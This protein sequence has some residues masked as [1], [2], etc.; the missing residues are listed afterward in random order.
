MATYD[1][2]PVYKASYDLLIETFTITKIFTKEY[3]YSLGD[4]VKTEILEIIVYI[5]KANSSFDNRVQHIKLA[6]EKIEVFRLYMRLCKDL[7][8]INLN[9][10]VDVNTKIETIGK[11]LYSWENSFS[12]K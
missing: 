6:R 8:L 7:K 4:K 11:Q 10:F 12:K 2:L 5:Y 3:K 9:K 1:N